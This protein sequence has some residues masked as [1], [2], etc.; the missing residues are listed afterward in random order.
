MIVLDA[1]ALVDILLD[2]PPRDWLLEQ[3]TDEIVCAPAHQPAEVLSA[4]ARLRRA[5]AISGE[6]AQQALT[7]A[8][9]LDQELV[10]PDEGHLQRA[11]QIQD[12][13]RILDGLYVVLAAER[14]C[15]LL[16]SDQRLAAAA[17]PCSVQSPPAQTGR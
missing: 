5:D 10:A 17:P 7:E 14:D 3:L 15:P 4:V 1:A 16:T 8:S 2:R 11:L 6:V 13:I 12:R 9:Q